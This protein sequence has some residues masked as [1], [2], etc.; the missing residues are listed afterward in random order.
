MRVQVLG[1][2]AGGGLPQ[3]NCGCRECDGAR[4]DASRRRRHA[5]LAVEVAPGRV[6]L[7]N[8]T[9]DVAEQLERCPWT[10]PRGRRSPLAGVILTDAELDHTL[11]LARLREADELEVMAASAVRRAAGDALGMLAAYVTLRWREPGPLGEDV[12]ATLEPISDKR[13]RYAEHMN[14]EGWVSALRLTAG[15]RSLLYAPAMGVWPDGF[16]EDAD[17]VFVDGT[18]YHED[19]P[20]RLG[21]SQRGATGMGHLPVEATRARLAALSARCFYI[22][23]NNTNPLNDPAGRLHTGLGVEVATEGMVLEL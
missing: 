6:Y 21:I 19:E 3:W 9:P 17:V 10:R 20:Q 13:P 11:G 23:L 4:A 2:A 7:V 22:H 1:T 15:G 16:G 8:A 18:F 12:T 14:G 5:S